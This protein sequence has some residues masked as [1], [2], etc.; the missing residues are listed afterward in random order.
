VLGN[1]LPY[2]WLDGGYLLQS[3]LWPFLGAAG[4]LNVTCI[5][6]MVLAVP[7]FALALKAGSLF[8]LIFWGLLFS[9]SYTARTQMATAGE[10]EYATSF[11]SGT[12]PEGRV[13]SGRWTQRK[14][15]RAQANRRKLE[16][17]IDAILA[18]VSAHGMHSLTWSE[19]RTLKKGS[20]RLR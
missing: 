18:K 7:M 5:I 20:E 10:E 12:G 1:L 11:Y 4:A 2:Y 8:G 3:L 6:G 14:N 9:S 16:Q 15:A 19:K 17:K 13:R